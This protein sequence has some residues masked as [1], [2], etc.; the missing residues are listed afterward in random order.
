[1]ERGR[2]NVPGQNANPNVQLEKRIG[3]RGDEKL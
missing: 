1:M 3:L 2:V